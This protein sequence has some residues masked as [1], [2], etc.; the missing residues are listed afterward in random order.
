[1]SSFAIRGPFAIE[2]WLLKNWRFSCESFKANI[3]FETLL[4]QKIQQKIAPPFFTK[5]NMRFSNI[6][7]KIVGF[8]FH[9]PNHPGSWERPESTLWEPFSRL[10]CFRGVRD[11]RNQR[12]TWQFIDPPFHRFFLVEISVFV[13]SVKPDFKY[14]INYKPCLVVSWNLSPKHVFFTKTHPKTPPKPGNSEH[15]FRQLLGWVSTIDCRPEATHRSFEASFWGS[16]AVGNWATG[17]SLAKWR[18]TRPPKI[19]LQPYL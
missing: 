11:L 2:P 7:P 19:G 1:M 5:K 13:V 18:P 16:F 15:L 9:Q 14:E 12:K 3:V 10:R 4:E 6:S 17:Q 8:F